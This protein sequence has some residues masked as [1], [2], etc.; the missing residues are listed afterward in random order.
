MSVNPSS[1][2][3]SLRASG[4]L[5]TNVNPLDVE[6][7]LSSTDGFGTLMTGEPYRCISART[8]YVSDDGQWDSFSGGAGSIT[9]NGQVGT[10]PSRA[11]RR[12]LASL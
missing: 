8:I 1:N 9:R 4:A 5:I 10:S 11:V 12:W 6:L 2:G 7:P 3:G